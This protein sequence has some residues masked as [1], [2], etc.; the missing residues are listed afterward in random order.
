MRPGSAMRPLLLL[1]AVVTIL[2]PASAGARLAVGHRI[3]MLDGGASI[4]SREPRT[5]DEL[6][7]LAPRAQSG[8]LVPR[9]LE[10][11]PTDLPSGVPVDPETVLEIRAMLDEFAA[12]LLSGDLL[13]GYAYFSDHSIQAAGPLD[14]RFL[15]ILA[16]TP[17]PEPDPTFYAIADISRA[18]RLA[19]GRVGAV[20]TASGGCERSQPEPTC[21]FYAIFVQAHGRWVIDEQIRELA[22]PDGVLT[23]PEYLERQGTPAATPA[24]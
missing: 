1:L 21:V 4:C 9:T 10:D 15:A 13:R 5:V 24:A 14:E 23:I 6:R 7:R 11:L 20:V 19:D 18:E 8:P 16:A 12:C 22:G 17:T 3:L 2:G